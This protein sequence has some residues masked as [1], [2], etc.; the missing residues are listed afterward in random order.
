MKSGYGILLAD[1]LPE[2][3]VQTSEP[4]ARS[5]NDSALDE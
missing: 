4:N 2:F 5:A 3:A 1:F